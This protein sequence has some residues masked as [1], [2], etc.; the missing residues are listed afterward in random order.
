MGAAAVTAR[1]LS[2][3]ALG[4]ALH[5][6]AE[7]TLGALQ[8]AE[9]VPFIGMAAKF[10]GAL[11]IKITAVRANDVLFA[12]LVVRLRRLQQ[13]LDSA[14]GDDVGGG[15]LTLSPAGIAGIGQ[16]GSLEVE[17]ASWQ[18]QAK[19]VLNVAAAVVDRAEASCLSLPFPSFSLKLPHS[20]LLG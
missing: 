13:A 18:S 7:I 1:A 8:L 11:V 6:A 14:G 12:T 19:L 10:I 9:A 3:E 4:A 5:V 2:S 20:I 16:S 17:D 15:L